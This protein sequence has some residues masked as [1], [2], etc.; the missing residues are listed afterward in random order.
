MCISP[1]PPPAV[2]VATTVAN[3]VQPGGPH[4]VS[5]LS[6]EIGEWVDDPFVDN[7]VNC[8]DNN[9]MEVGEIPSRET[10]TMARLLTN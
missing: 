5:A 1:I 9:I 3:G 2:S 10:P 6:H 7:D 8:L 4:D